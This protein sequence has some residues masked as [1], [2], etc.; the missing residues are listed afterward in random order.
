MVWL[1]WGGGEGACA[2]GI[3]DQIREQ[4]IASRLPHESLAARG[5]LRARAP[6]GAP[7]CARP[8]AA[9]AALAAHRH[10]PPCRPPFPTIPHPV[11]PP[12]PCVRARVH[13]K[14]RKYAFVRVAGGATY[15]SRVVLVV[16]VRYTDRARGRRVVR[17]S[18]KE[19]GAVPARRG[20]VHARLCA[21]WGIL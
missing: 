7:H 15:V 1:S 17:R 18:L 12:A 8:R 11:S 13:V 9:L 4:R 6:H 16:R 5:A 3:P 19:L 14:A 2:R 20:V 10:T 21:R